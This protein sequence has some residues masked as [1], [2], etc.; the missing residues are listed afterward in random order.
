[1]IEQYFEHKK[2]DLT[3]VK[4]FNKT[5]DACKNQVADNQKNKNMFEKSG[6]SGVMGTV[7]NQNQY[8]KREI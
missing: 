4:K 3:L 7:F 5:H 8:A 1:M 6:D 2:H